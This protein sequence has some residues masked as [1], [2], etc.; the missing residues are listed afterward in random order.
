MLS[1]VRFTVSS[2]MPTLKWSELFE[3]TGLRKL[4]S[5][6]GSPLMKADTYLSLCS[7]WTGASVR[8][9]S[10]GLCAGFIF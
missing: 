6:F 3:S 8:S 10:C 9:C 2:S 1:P 7:F 5:T 4:M